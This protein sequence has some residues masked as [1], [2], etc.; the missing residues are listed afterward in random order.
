MEERLLASNPLFFFFNLILIMRA[1]K[2]KKYQESRVK[3]NIGKVVYI[4]TRNIKTHFNKKKKTP[5]EFSIR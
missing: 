1:R 3:N 5:I 4:H 2:G